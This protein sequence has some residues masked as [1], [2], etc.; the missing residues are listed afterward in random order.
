M[1]VMTPMDLVTFQTDESSPCG[2]HETKSYSAAWLQEAAS[3]I[4]NTRQR[5]Y[6]LK[7]SSL[8]TLE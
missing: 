8:A 2:L 5:T 6:F 7:I 1:I 4:L 3:L